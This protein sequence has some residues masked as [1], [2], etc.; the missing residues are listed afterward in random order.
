MAKVE[1]VLQKRE[2][3]NISFTVLQKRLKQHC[4]IKKN[5]KNT[6]SNQ[7]F[8]VLMSKAELL[9]RTLNWKLDENAKEMF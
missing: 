7:S 8:H 4:L 2:L 9:T 5:L 1:F 3:K 6:F